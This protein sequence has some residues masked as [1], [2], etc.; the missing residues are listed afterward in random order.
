[1]KET[2][3]ISG[4]WIG[5]NDAL[6]NIIKF[7]S[8]TLNDVVQMACINPSVLAQ[9]DDSKG[10][11]AVGKDADMIILSKDLDVTTT[12]VNGEIVFER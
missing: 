7:T 2:G 1:M 4:S 8:C 11:L 12:I 9:V 3:R 5:M 6:K 10:T